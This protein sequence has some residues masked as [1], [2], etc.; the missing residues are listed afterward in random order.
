MKL[1]DIVQKRSSFK[2]KITGKEYFLR[3]FTPNDA[4]AVERQIGNVNNVLRT[5]KLSDLFKVAYILLE[6]ESTLDFKSREVK[7]VDFEG[8]EKIESVGGYVLFASMIT[9][10]DEQ[11]EVM[12]AVFESIGVPEKDIKEFLSEKDKAL[13]VDVEPQDIDKKKVNNAKKTKRT[14]RK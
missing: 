4:I 13:S 12:R 5:S 8:K 2:L 6:P 11:F 9:N 1:I 7:F 3:P 14:G 10:L